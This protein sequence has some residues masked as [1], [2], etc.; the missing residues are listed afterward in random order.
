M[1]VPTVDHIMSEKSITF[2]SRRDD[3]DKTMAR[4]KNLKVFHQMRKFP[5]HFP[6]PRQLSYGSLHSYAGCRLPSDEQGNDSARCSGVQ[7]H[8]LQKFPLFSPPASNVSTTYELVYW[9]EIG[10]H[11]HRK[12]TCIHVQYTAKEEWIMCPIRL[13]HTNLYLYH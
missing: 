8:K 9:P 4:E 5:E 1:C 10:L 12:R 6:R 3:I 7:S 13:H 2:K 11:P